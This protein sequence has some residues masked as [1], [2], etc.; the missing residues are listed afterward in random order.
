MSSTHHTKDVKRMTLQVCLRHRIPSVLNMLRP[1]L[2][3]LSQLKCVWALDLNWCLASSSSDAPVNLPRTTNIELFAWF[4]TSKPV[5]NSSWFEKQKNGDTFMHSRFVSW[6]LKNTLPTLTR[7]WHNWKKYVNNL[8]IKQNK[9]S[10]SFL[11][12]YYSLK[13]WFGNHLEEI[14]EINHQIL[15]FTSFPSCNKSVHLYPSYWGWKKP[16]K[17]LST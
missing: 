7:T 15:L 11:V 17:Y 8:G 12:L 16:W 5:N 4:I 2:L 9:L 13:G 14:M 1:I 6:K 3:H 10:L